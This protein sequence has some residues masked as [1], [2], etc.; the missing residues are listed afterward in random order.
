MDCKDVLLEIR[1]NSENI[2]MIISIENFVSSFLF[3]DFHSLI[4]VS[5]TSFISHVIRLL[6]TRRNYRNTYKK[7]LIFHKRGQVM[8]PGKRIILRVKINEKNIRYFFIWIFH[9]NIATFSYYTRMLTRPPKLLTYYITPDT[10]TIVFSY[11]YS[12]LILYGM[13]YFNLSFNYLLNLLCFVFQKNFM[14]TVSDSSI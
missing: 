8:Q 2:T 9:L 11:M 10:L 3:S 6:H 5:H 4:V 12:Q 7:F 1:F 13:T 14:I